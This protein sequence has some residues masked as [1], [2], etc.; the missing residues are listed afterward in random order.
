M[1]NEMAGVAVQLC[2]SLTRRILDAAQAARHNTKSVAQARVALR[3]QRLPAFPAAAAAAAAADEAACISDA[4]LHRI[5][6]N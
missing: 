1:C 6:E 2:L 4:Q 3:L 5:V